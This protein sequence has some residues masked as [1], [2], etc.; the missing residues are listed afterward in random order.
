MHWFVPSGCP[1]PAVGGVPSSHRL[2]A[3]VSTVANT[4]PVGTV[5]PV[6]T[7]DSVI[8]CV[9]PMLECPTIC[10]QAGATS[11]KNAAAATA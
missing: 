11:E 4:V 8:D 3:A 1:T 5:R 7:P 10:P 2:A 6:A 9:A